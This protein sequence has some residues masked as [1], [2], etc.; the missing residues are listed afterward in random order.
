MSKTACYLDHKFNNY[1][2][3]KLPC[4]R[5]ASIIDAII[6]LILFTPVLIQ[7]IL[8]RIQLLYNIRHHL[9]N[10]T[11]VSTRNF[12]GN[13]PAILFLI[14]LILFIIWSVVNVHQIK[15][16]PMRFFIVLPLSIALY[17]ASYSVGTGLSAITYLSKLFIILGLFSFIIVFM[18]KAVTKNRSDKVKKN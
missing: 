5:K 6:G 7:S 14:S 8:V 2:E 9:Y 16:N 17:L 10:S 4:L 1:N 13:S 3:D 15:Q 18:A 11:I 12:I